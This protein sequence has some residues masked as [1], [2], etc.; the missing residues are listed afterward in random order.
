MLFA[1]P[2]TATFC[3][4]SSRRRRISDI[5]FVS[6]ASLRAM[7]TWSHMMAPSSRWMWRIVLFPFTASSWLIRLCT[8]SAACLNASWS[9][10][11]FGSALLAR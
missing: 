10:E 9:V 5:A 6:P 8:L 3:Q 7:P 4:N 1:S 11:T 2:G